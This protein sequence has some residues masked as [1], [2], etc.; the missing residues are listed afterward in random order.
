MKPDVVDFDISNYEFCQRIKDQH[1]LVAKYIDYRETKIRVQVG[2]SV[3]LPKYCKKIMF[4]PD[5]IDPAEKDKTL[6]P[7]F[8]P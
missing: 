3:S 5:D 1:N 6:G 8:D 4:L 2:K 7:G